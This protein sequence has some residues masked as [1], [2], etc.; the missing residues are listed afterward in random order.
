METYYAAIRFGPVTPEVWKAEL[1]ELVRV[2]DEDRR[3]ELGETDW[4]DT[5]A[6]FL[7]EITDPEAAWGAS[8]FEEL[9]T[10]LRDL[11]VPY[12]CWDDGKYD[13]CGMTYK[14][15]PGMTAEYEVM[16][17]GD[18]GTPVLTEAEFRRLEAGASAAELVTAI[19]RHF[20]EEAVPQP[21]PT[22]AAFDALLVTQAA[23]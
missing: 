10:S 14:W 11:G 9:R 20:G 1:E 17:D 3:S 19:R 23:G 4:H 8:Q 15:A 6:G 5:P 18:S 2:D 22:E 12:V 13:A 7:G 16:N 21:H